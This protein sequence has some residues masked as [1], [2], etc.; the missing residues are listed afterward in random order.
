MKLLLRAT[1]LAVCLGGSV[2]LLGAQQQQG[3]GGCVS[4]CGSVEDRDGY[5][6]TVWGPTST[7]NYCDSSPVCQAPLKEI[8][9]W[10]DLP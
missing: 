5:C 3:S 7:S 1:S 8:L 9:C 6:R 2:S 10:Y 4:Y